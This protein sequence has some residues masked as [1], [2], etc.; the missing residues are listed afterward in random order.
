MGT[1]E[2]IR[3]LNK[4]RKMPLKRL[5]KWLKFM[6]DE[7]D[8]LISTGE[9]HNMHVYLAQPN[10]KGAPHSISTI[11]VYNCP[12]CGK[13]SLQCYDLKSDCRF[14]TVCL[15]RARNAAILEVDRERFFKEINAY[16]TTL[17][18]YRWHVGGDI[19]DLD[20]FKHVIKIALDNPQ[21]K[22]H[23]FTKNYDAVNTWLAEQIEVSEQFGDT[24]EPKQ[25]LPSNLNL[26]F[27]AWP[28]LPMDNPYN[29]PTAEVVDDDDFVI[30]KPNSAIC[31]KNCTQCA[32]HNR[33]CFD[34]NI[35]TV[36]LPLH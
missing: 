35:E 21:C 14:D 8:R 24:S 28:G 7:K 6:I 17:D 36:Y 30:T 23:I 15:T 32:I 18:K 33:D 10:R 1:E 34:R 13:C 11:P 29:I 5:P 16:C 19:L 26:R 20:Y 25:L 22:F 31:S 2:Q 27:S 3:F 12:N 4:I 9:V